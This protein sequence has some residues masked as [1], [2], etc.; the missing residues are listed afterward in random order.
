MAGVYARVS[1]LKDWLGEN[2]CLMSDEQPGW[3]SSVDL[4]LMNDTPSANP[5]PEPPTPFPTRRPTT[6][7]TDKPTN[8]PTWQPTPEPSEVPITPEPSPDPT[9]APTPNP[10]R[11]PTVAIP[12]P[13]PAPV[14]LVVNDV[15][16]KCQDQNELFE[17]GDLR[18]GKTCEWLRTSH[19][20]I[21]EWFCIPGTDAWNVCEAACE[22]C[23]DN[24]VNSDTA[25]FAVTD[26]DTGVTET[27][28]C[29]WLDNT[30]AMQ[31]ELCVS[32]S[33]AHENCGRTCGTCTASSR[34]KEIY[35]EIR[36][37]FRR[38]PVRKDPN[39]R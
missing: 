10:T 26:K 18:G 32:G 36:Y 8:E 12:S 31:A 9:P 15:Q 20:D 34:N 27:R 29:A 6:A 24:C 37:T 3:C 21:R 39:G 14:D 38:P 33:D 2:I 25:V 17:A 16:R 1:G 22:K 30:Q 28:N 19:E 7:P 35:E 13:T 5:T 11:S 23:D 4:A